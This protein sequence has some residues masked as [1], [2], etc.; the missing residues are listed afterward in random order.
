MRF[1][2]RLA[3]ALGSRLTRQ[4]ARGF[5]HVGVLH[6]AGRS[7]AIGFS[8][9]ALIVFGNLVLR[10]LEGLFVFLELR[11]LR[12]FPGFGHLLLLGRQGRQFGESSPRQG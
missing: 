4:F 12:L 7:R 6:S 1:R 2:R 5:R 10:A 8:F 11:L 3:A 9:G